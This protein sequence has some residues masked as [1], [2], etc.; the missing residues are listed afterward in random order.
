VYLLETITAVGDSPGTI[1]VVG[2]NTGH[3]VLCT[4]ALVGESF[5]HRSSNLESFL[6]NIVGLSQPILI[7]SFAY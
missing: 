6:I 1:A 7:L 3:K 4:I 2:E 5:G